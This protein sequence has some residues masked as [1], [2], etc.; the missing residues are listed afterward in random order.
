MST[1]DT[2]KRFPDWKKVFVA[3]LEKQIET[4]LG[5][6]AID[7]IKQP[8]LQ[9]ELSD[10]LGS[11]YDAVEKQFVEQVASDEIREAVLG[12][13]LA[14]LPSLQQAFGEFFRQPQSDKLKLALK[15]Q[16][17]MDYPRLSE[18][19]I[20]SAIQ[21]YTQIL[22]DELLPLSEQ[23]QR[24]SM[25]YSLEKISNHTDQLGVMTSL[26]KELVG[27]VKN[28]NF[29]TSDQS[30][31]KS[32]LTQPKITEGYMPSNSMKNI[33]FVLVTALEEERDALLG[34]LPG[35]QPLPPSDKDTNFY[36]FAELPVTFADNSNG[37]YKII[38]LPLLGMGRVQAATATTNA[39]QH[40]KPRYV[41]LVGIAGGLKSAGV[42]IGDILIPD[43]IV[44]YELQKITPEGPEV[45]WKV[46]HS[47]PRML[48]GS[49]NFSMDKVLGYIQV[50]RPTKGEPKR[51]IGSIAS[52]DKVIAFGDVLNKYRGT[53]PKLIGAEME[54]AG[55]A[56]AAFQADSQPG[57]FMVRAVSDMADNDKGTPHVEKWRTYACDMAA[58]YTIALLKSGPIQAVI[59][60]TPAIH[61]RPE[62]TDYEQYPWQP[63]MSYRYLESLDSTRFN[64]LSKEPEIKMLNGKSELLEALLFGDGIALSE[65]QLIDSRGAV[66][67]LGELIDAAKDVGVRIPV[68]LASR[69][70]GQSVFDLVSNTIGN[71]DEAQLNRRYVISAN[72][73]LDLDISRRKLWS[74]QLAQG[75]K[76]I[77]GILKNCSISESEF[78][79]SL[80]TTLNYIDREG[81]LVI[82]ARNEPDR[83]YR[84][85]EQVSKLTTDDLDAM[86]QQ[87]RDADIPEIM[88][89]QWFANRNEAEAAAKLIAGLKTIINKLGGIPKVRSPIY[90]ELAILEKENPLL[91]EG[92]KEV[93]DSIYNHVVGLAGSADSLSDTTGGNTQNILVCAGHAV[94]QWARQ[95][96]K[97]EDGDYRYE[98]PWAWGGTSQLTWSKQL[99]TSQIKKVV[100]VVPWQAILEATKESAWKESLVSYRTAVNVLQAVD[101]GSISL[102]VMGEQW[103][104]KHLDA[105]QALTDAWN[106]HIE[107]S[108]RLIS[109]QYWKIT[110]DGMQYYAPEGGPHPLQAS[111]SYRT[112]GTMTDF[113]VEMQQFRISTQRKE[114]ENNIYGM[115]NE[116]AQKRQH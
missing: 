17:K 97:K 65:P 78:V 4:V 13:P 81:G 88:H 112:M 62:W 51:H 50:K 9:K 107:I 95:T 30:E 84:E 26:L 80:F 86:C 74:Q 27:H 89:P 83:F 72:P 64:D 109:N 8:Y 39:I 114:F 82:P 57:F 36:Y 92:I 63:F 28:N 59:K 25:T 68:R 101:R 108:A 29:A 111:Q 113:P 67:A 102:G 42:K 87:K 44:D 11:I 103:R 1:R 5:N 41:L 96:E 91:A 21:L 77:G 32:S 54:A 15:S 79:T 100:K 40:W 115:I 53:W 45:R 2:D 60:G 38:V 31:Y 19:H 7:E 46:Y 14:S 73:A 76:G 33:D 106:K 52:G 61:L 23:F 22:H 56:A 116:I 47:D 58:S 98:L 20:D 94:S 71:I 18:E 35:Y 70:P 48:G 90:T 69:N 85:V 93:V 24:M 37:R 110:S 16:L 55:V 3:I 104:Q 75:M 6:N 99:D 34:K 43:Q 105:H 66:D 12:L 49:K 10:K